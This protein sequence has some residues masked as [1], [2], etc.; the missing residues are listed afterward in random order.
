MDN[1]TRRGFFGFSAALGGAFLV[2]CGGTAAQ[3]PGSALDAD[4]LAGAARAH[5]GRVR[6]PT[7]PV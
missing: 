1:L 7:C 5:P 4:A 3:H 6:R 2:G